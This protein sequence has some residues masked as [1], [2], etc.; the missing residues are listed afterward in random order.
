M[1]GRGTFAEPSCR[2]VNIVA[3]GSTRTFLLTSFAGQDQ[4]LT[5]SFKMLLFLYWHEIE[6]KKKRKEKET[7][8]PCSNPMTV[9]RCEHT[10]DD[11]QLPGSPGCKFL[12]RGVRR[13]C[14]MRSLMWR[15][16]QNA[17]NLNHFCHAPFRLWGYFRW[18]ITPSFFGLSL[19]FFTACSVSIALQVSME[20]TKKIC[21]SKQRYGE[22]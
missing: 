5:S 6:N 11:L 19:A 10:A 9:S 7:N 12:P 20:K 8:E 13:F 17:R 21:I 22:P 16:K 4:R 18:L 2:H 3:S 14:L 1:P 15:Q